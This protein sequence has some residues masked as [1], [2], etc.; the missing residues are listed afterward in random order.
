MQQIYR[1]NGWSRGISPSALLS[2]IFL[3]VPYLLNL[4]FKLKSNSIYLFN[5]VPNLGHIG[6]EA[7]RGGRERHIEAEWDIDRERGGGSLSSYPD[8]PNSDPVG[9]NYFSPTQP[10]PAPAGCTPPPP[11]SMS[12]SLSV[13]L[14]G[15]QHSMRWIYSLCSSS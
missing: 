7:R 3:W 11:L 1:W 8:S 2:S 12:L 10:A 5:W 9:N 13:F 14:W 4:D 6:M 15:W